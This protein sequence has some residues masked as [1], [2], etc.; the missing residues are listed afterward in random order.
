MNNRKNKPFNK[1]T[2]IICNSGYKRKFTADIRLSQ[3]EFSL[4][5]HLS[6]D[7]EKITDY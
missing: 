6:N 5:K 2:L 3:M 4:Q 7:Y 1:M